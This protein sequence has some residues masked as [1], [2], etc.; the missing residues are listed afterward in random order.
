[1]SIRRTAPLVSALG[2]LL[3]M[4][5]GPPDQAQE[6]EAVLGQM[7]TEERLRQST[8]WPRKTFDRATD[9]VGSAACGECHEAILE[10]QGTTSMARTLAPSTVTP[11]SSFGGEFQLGPYR[12]RISSGPEGAGFVV[13]DGADS[14]AAPI[15]WVFGSGATGH[16]YLWRQDTVFHESRFSYFPHLAAFAETPGRLRGL[17]DSLEMALSH[18]LSEHEATGCFSC[19]STAMVTAD[20]FDPGRLT[21]GVTCEGCHGPGADHVALEKSGLDSTGAIFN[22]GH[23]GPD[24][25]LDFCGACH[26]TFWDTESGAPPALA[27]IRFP[28][29]RLVKSKCWGEGSARLTCTACHDPHQPLVREAAS[30]DAA[31]LACHPA[32]PPRPAD[33]HLPSCSVATDRC[34]TCHMQEYE[35]PEMHVKATDH[36]IRI[37]RE[38]EPLP[39]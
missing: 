37:V 24:D 2:V 7:T 30:Y 5:A 10:T 14:L 26:G 4:L 32:S 13:S 31:C 28:G 11:G 25:A 18:P 19:H 22:S 39:P 33:G 17:P 20:G 35:V 6:L 15:E 1:M 34:V 9:H 21:P 27:G 36:W 8:W 12:Y 3:A 23:L 16:S 38:G 29:Y